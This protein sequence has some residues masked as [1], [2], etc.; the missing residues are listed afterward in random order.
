MGKIK[1]RDQM[2]T[3]KKPGVLTNEEK[4]HLE[5]SM[6]HNDKLMKQLARM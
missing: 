5:D 3:E 1:S 4:K 2:Q 6:R